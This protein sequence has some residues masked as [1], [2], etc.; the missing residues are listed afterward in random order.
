MAVESKPLFHP[1]AMRQQARAFS[2]PEHVAAWQANP[3]LPRARTKRGATVQPEHAPLPL[4]KTG[5]RC[6]GVREE[7]ADEPVIQR[8]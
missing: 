4:F 8:E 2:L 7:S 3:R 5:F 6:I 1:E